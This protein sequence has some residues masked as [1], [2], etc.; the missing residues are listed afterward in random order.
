ME[1]DILTEN[2]FPA[3]P[4]MEQIYITSMHSLFQ[5]HY[6]FGFEFSG[7][8]HDFWECLYILDGELC[9]S[10]DE[11]IYNMSRGELI[12]H[13]PL[14]FH[15]FTVKSAEGASLLIF[16]FSAEGP[17]TLWLHDKVFQLSIEQ[18]EMIASLLIY[19][20]K[21]TNAIP[22]ETEKKEHYYLQPFEKYPYY[23]QMV[24]SSLY[25]LFLSL[26][27]QGTVSS[28]SL[29]PDAITFRNAINFLNQKLNCQP[30]VSEIAK[31]CNVSDASLKRIFDKY[32]GI[33]VHKYLLKRK[34]NMAKQLL[35]EGSQVSMVAENLGF[36]S[37]SYFSKA[38]KRETGFTP[39]DFAKNHDISK[40]TYSNHIMS[41]MEV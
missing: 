2:K 17:L 28:V 41:E 15:K 9:V 1:G 23:S 38:F 29:A 35:Q 39:S 14:E 12:F 40:S 36:A 27:E 6:E 25:Q 3:I 24:V 37:Q 31:Y 26:A 21:K 30:T 4:I 7:E 5:S 11:R 19:M 10:A 13:K 16:S 18:E 20:K 33:S 8:T 32:A 22:V 34:I